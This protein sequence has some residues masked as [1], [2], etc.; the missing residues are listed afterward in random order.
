MRGVFLS[1]QISYKGVGL[2]TK[3]VEETPE[4]VYVYNLCC[5]MVRLGKHFLDKFL[6]FNEKFNLFASYLHQ[7]PVF[8]SEE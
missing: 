1:R 3:Q 4:F 6:L 2:I 5:Q 8:V 7:C